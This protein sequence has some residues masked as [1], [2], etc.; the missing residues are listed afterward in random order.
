M[1]YGTG[2]P[3]VVIVV[4]N[5]NGK[6]LTLE[7]L[8]SLRKLTYPNVQVV[9][10]DNASVDGSV[11][12]VCDSFPEVMVLRMI[13]NLG[14]AGGSNEGIR[15]AQRK[16]AACILLLNNDTVVDEQCL[17]HLVTRILSDQSIG[18][19]APKIY[20]YSDSRRIW[21][22]GG[23]LSFWKGVMWHTGIRDEDRGQYDVALETEFA[24]GCCML[25]AGEVIERVGLL[26]ESFGMYSEDVDWSMRAR[27]AGYRIFYEPKAIVWHKVSASAGGNLSWFK[28]KNKFLSNMKF[29][30]R[31]AAWYHWLVFPWLSMAINAGL[32]VKHKFGL[33]HGGEALSGSPTQTG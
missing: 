23:M 6:E 33:S 11:E 16:G 9:L 13:S 20:Y 14:F 22:A 21:Y 12:A 4:V 26:D 30:R 1:K 17:G 32:F 25:V 10:V 2:D 28:L 7:C 29:F 3:L 31:Y 27:K 18:I 15:A 5:W 24:S 8:S 19:V